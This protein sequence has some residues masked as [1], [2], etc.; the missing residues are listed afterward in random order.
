MVIRAGGKKTPGN[1]A[2]VEKALQKAGLGHLKADIIDRSVRLT[3]T[4]ETW[5]QKV[6]AGYAAA[7]KG[8]RGVLNDIVA[9]EAPEAPM[10]EPELEDDALEGR[11]YDVVIVGAGV[12]GC[13][14]ARELSRYDLSIAVIEKEEDAAMQAS[15]RNDGMI[16]PGFAAKPGTRKAFYNVRGNRM[17]GRWAEELNFELKR[18]G[19]LLLY[20]TAF[21]RLLVPVFKMRCR[22]N[23]VD[24][25]YRSLSAAEVRRMERWV[26][27]KQKGA[28]F[29]PSAGIV[30]PYRVT[31]A[32]AE[33]AAQNG[34]EFHFRTVLRDIRMEEGR[35][36][37]LVTNRGIFGC[38]LL[39]NAAGVWSDKV[40]EMAGDRFFS[41]HGRKGTDAILDAVCG[42]FQTRIS[43]MPRIF[44]G[45]SSHSK[46]GGVVPCVEGNL[47]IGPTAQEVP[48][49]EDFSTDAAVFQSLLGQLDLNKALSSRYIINYYSGVRAA[50]WEEDFIVGPSDKVANLVHAAG[51]QSPGLASAPA[52]AE[53]IAGWAVNMLE[54]QGRY[55]SDNPGFNPVRTPIPSLRDMDAAERDALIHQDP[56]YGEILC[57]CEEVSRGE[58]RDA[59]RRNPPATTVDGVKRRVRAG[60]G[61]CH[62]GFCLPRIIGVMAEEMGLD[63]LEI[64]KKG[65]GSEIAVAETKTGA[66]P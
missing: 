33:N 40:A 50:T 58:I 43:G 9:S 46:G 45:R 19:S 57:R 21:H 11:S 30:S 51:I 62:G 66:A 37:E 17:Y 39:V 65:P 54:A 29:M 10:A 36:K 27:D 55:V 13:A 28:F 56:S 35:I 8:Y 49:R 61:R 23:G 20:R 31:L 12:I 5:E 44:S 38:G 16:H 60:A 63:L 4:V 22:R 47:L 2:A 7:G 48:G 15:G 34:C 32:L 41:I 42:V 14:I 1:P 59:L 25:E 64:S 24:G 52:I 18:P 53:D 26:T 3:G 6:R